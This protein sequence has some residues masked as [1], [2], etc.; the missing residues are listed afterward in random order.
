MTNFCPNCGNEIS[1][2]KINFCPECGKATKVASHRPVEGW[3]GTDQYFDLDM[4]GVE[5]PFGCIVGKIISKATEIVYCLSDISIEQII[6]I[7]ADLKAF[8]HLSRRYTDH[9]NL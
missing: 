1:S 3:N 4:E 6:K 2:D 7:E 5:F 9:T 8:L